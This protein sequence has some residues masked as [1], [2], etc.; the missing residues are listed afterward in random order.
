MRRKLDLAFM[1]PEA[2]MP[3]LEY[4]V[5]VKEPLVVV[6]PSDHR[7]ASC[8]TIALQDIV[9]E[10]FLG[11]SDTAPTL[12]I[13]IDDYLRRSGINLRPAHKIDNLGMAMS[14]VA[15]TRGVTLLPAYAKNFLPWSV[16]SRPLAGEPPTIDLVVGYNRANTSP[17]LQLFLSKLDD[18]ISPFR[19]RTSEAAGLPGDRTTQPSLAD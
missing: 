18:L 12:Q 13:I 8:E 5:I 1:R 3:D 11:M 6:L 19:M 2:Q 10:I 16:I 17:T 7:L 9:D 14:L 15:S 4:K